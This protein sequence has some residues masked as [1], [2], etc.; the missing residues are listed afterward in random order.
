MICKVAVRVHQGVEHIW[1]HCPGCGHAHG[2]PTKRWNWNGCTKK[3]TLS[4]SVRHYI[5]KME[6]GEITY[7]EQT[8]CHYF[9]KDGFI[10]F[11]GDCPHPLAG[12]KV[13]LQEPINVPDNS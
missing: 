13:E 12:Q 2:V 6:E 3:P 7:P 5:P 4:P 1:Y 9:I 10:E 11:C 8:I